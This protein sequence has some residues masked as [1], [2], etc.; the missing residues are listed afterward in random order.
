M[1]GAAYVIVADLILSAAVKHGVREP[2]SDTM[3]GLDAVIGAC[4]WLAY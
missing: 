4:S 2:V 3:A 1:S